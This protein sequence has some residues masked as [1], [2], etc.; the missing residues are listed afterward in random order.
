MVLGYCYSITNNPWL[1]A[2]PT[3]RSIR[4][5]FVTVFLALNRQRVGDAAPFCSPVC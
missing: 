1:Q 2:V 4:A 3:S 5:N